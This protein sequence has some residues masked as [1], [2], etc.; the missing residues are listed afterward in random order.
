[1]NRPGKLGLRVA[2]GEAIEDVA[3]ALPY[4]ALVDLRFDAFNDGRSYSKARL[5]RERFGF[6]GAPIRV[7]LRRGKNPYAPR[8]R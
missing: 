7:L 2:S 8:A 4:V 3:D 6:A 5:L 1:M